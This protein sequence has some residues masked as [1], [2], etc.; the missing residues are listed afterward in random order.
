MAM[1]HTYVATGSA[2][3]GV[4]IGI[5]DSAESADTAEFEAVEFTKEEAFAF[6]WSIIESVTRSGFVAVARKR[7][8]L[9]RTL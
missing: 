1:P 5:A 4:R 3:P 7:K 8:P 6:A 2:Y 9:G